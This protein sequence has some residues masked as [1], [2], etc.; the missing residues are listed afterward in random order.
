[1]ELQSQETSR[2]RERQPGLLSILMVNCNDLRFLNGSLGSI[3]ERV[4]VPHE[5]ILLDNA[6][7]DGSPEFVQDKF[8]EVKVVRS[9]ENLGFIRG[10][11]MAARHACGEFYLMLNPDTIL[12]ADIASAVGLLQA[13]STIGAVGAAM[14]GGDGK[15]LT[16]CGH[17]PSILRLT[18]IKSMFWRPYRGSYGPKEF[19]AKRV[20]WVTGAWLLTTA[21]IWE[22][23]GGLDDRIFMYGDDV[24]YCRRIREHGKVTVYMPSIAYTHFV[25][26]S[27]KRLP[28]IYTSLRWFHRKFSGSAGRHLADFVMKAGLYVRVAVFRTLTLFLRDQK[29]RD[30]WQYAQGVLDVWPQ[31]GAPGARFD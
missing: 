3:R 7:H 17:F 26:F 27:R 8:P 15:L 29:Y 18:L 1:M 6:S 5:V 30:Y 28:Y 9:S 21:S 22:K 12:Q 14:Y 4:R 2:L 31:T 19:G 23:V 13:D 10:T 20:D 11:N 25:G 16:G 24:D